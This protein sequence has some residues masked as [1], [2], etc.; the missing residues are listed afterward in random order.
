M[1][2]T[3]CIII[4]SAVVFLLG[5]YSSGFA[6]DSTGD[7]NEQDESQTD[8]KETSVA[9]E[10]T[11]REDLESQTLD[12][13]GQM[14]K[15]GILLGLSA[16]QKFLLVTT[17]RGSSPAGEG[18]HKTKISFSP[19][20]GYVSEFNRIGESNFQ[21]FYMTSLN[22]FTSKEQEVAESS[23]L[24]DLGTSAEVIAVNFTPT[25]VYKHSF[26]DYSK[27]FGGAGFG[28]G[29]L[30]AK[31]NAYFTEQTVS[32]ACS[33]AANYEGE[34]DLSKIKNHCE[35]RDFD[36]SSFSYSVS[37]AFGYRYKNF[38]MNI[39]GGSPYIDKDDV[40]YQVGGVSFDFYYVLQF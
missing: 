18:R 10:E 14:L 6:Q 17:E 26:S 34:K 27:I 7:V 19:S 31:G 4:I 11:F 29:Y 23:E 21:Y 24:Y 1:N 9:E 40:T 5:C 35:L 28:V 20:A 39:V 22:Q 37:L 2:R 16:S 38:Y 25:L 15:G 13:A 33:E 30:K 36:I 32:S 3:Y 12:K 8:V